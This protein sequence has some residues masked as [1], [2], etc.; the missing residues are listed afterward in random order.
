MENAVDELGSNGFDRMDISLLASEHAVTDKLGHAYVSAR[1]LEDD[2][3][4]P[5]TAFVSRASLGAAEGAVVGTLIYIPALIG[6]AA[7]VASGGAVAAAIAAAAVAGGIG[8]GIG[9][10]LARLIDR[11]HA[12]RIEEQLEHGGLLLF[13]RTRDAAHEARAREILAKHS[14]RDVHVHTVPALAG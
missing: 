6:A 11:A 14:G 5:T 2:P 9:T 10:L 8:G 12:N 3:S 4:V 1:E 7:V 13:V